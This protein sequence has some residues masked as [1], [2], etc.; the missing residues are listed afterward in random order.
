MKRHDIPKLMIIPA[1]IWLTLLVSACSSTPV[2]PSANTVATETPVV[3]TTV[4][5]QPAAENGRIA[6]GE[7]ASSIAART[8][9]P[10]P[11]PNLVDQQ[12]NEFTTATGLADSTFLGLTAENWINLAISILI[13]VAGYL[14]TTRLLRYF[15]RRVIRRTA[16]AFYETILKAIVP[17]LKWLV[18][19]FFL[20]FAVLRL[21]FLS[22]GL[23][24]ALDDIFFIVGLAVFTRIAL[25]LISYTVEWYKQ[26]FEPKKDEARLDPMILLLQ[27]AGY[28]LVIIIAIILGLAHFGITNNIL[29]TLLI[30]IVVGLLLAAKDT[31]SDVINGFIILI[32]QPFRPGDAI[33]VEGWDEWGWV[34]DIGART[35]RVR[36]WDNQLVIV[37][38]ARINAGQVINYTY[39]D[40]SY[41]M[42]T[43][44]RLAYGADLA[45]IRRVIEKTIRGIEEVMPDKPV[46]ILFRQF[47]EST[48]LIRVHWWISNCDKQFTMADRVNDALEQSLAEAGFAISFTTLDLNLNTVEKNGD[49][50]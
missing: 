4:E 6:S 31:I 39:P 26:Y 2:G 38:N 21:D 37:P 16:T 1:L 47:G 40:P 50:I 7:I 30:I 44:I 34:A 10:T 8:P 28:V 29:S 9:V 49:Q 46:E 41:R 36:T 20:R 15:V 33:Q 5:S 17:E 42:R 48:R 13:L 24:T 27:H 23:R 14:L 43:D 32:D 3:E 22:S 12:I 18:G 11:T 45:Q 25:K 19:L 35:T